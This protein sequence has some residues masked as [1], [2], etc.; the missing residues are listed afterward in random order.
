MSLAMI[1]IF[2]ATAFAQA[3]GGS[4]DGQGSGAHSALE[5]ANNPSPDGKFTLTTDLKSSTEVTFV[6][7]DLSG[8]PVYTERAFGPNVVSV[9]PDLSAL[10]SGSYIA[11]KYV[12]GVQMGKTIIKL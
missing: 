7:Y 10:P 9:F 2:S 4:K 1:M 5:I 12:D 6:I 8:V 3:G 11:T